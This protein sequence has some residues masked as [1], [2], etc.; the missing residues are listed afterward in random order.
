MQKFILPSLT[1]W[2]KK[3]LMA[4]ATQVLQ[5]Q[6]QMTQQGENILHYT[7][8]GLERHVRMSHYPQNDRID[9]NS[10][11]QY[12]YHC[13]RENFESAEHGHFHCF[14]RYP[15]IPKSIKPAALSDWDLYMDNPMTHLIAIGMNQMGQPIRLFTVNRWVTSELWYDAE[16]IPRLLRRYQMSLIDPYWEALDRWVEGLLHLFTPQ[17]IWLHQERARAIQTHQNN[18]PQQNSFLNQ[19]IEE[20]SE[21]TIDLKTQIEWIIGP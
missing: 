8:N 19:E 4:Y 11:A 16:K 18:F 1:A 14:L 6:Q 15:Q 5:A 13:H 9:Q 7:L 3:R 12:F 2:K 20:L 17:I 10:G 21:I